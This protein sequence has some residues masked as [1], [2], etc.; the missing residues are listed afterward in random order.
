MDATLSH[1]NLMSG[2][3]EGDDYGPCRNR[4]ASDSNPALLTPK[5]AAKALPIAPRQGRRMLLCSEQDRDARRETWQSASAGGS[6][7]KGVLRAR[8]CT[9]AYVKTIFLLGSRSRVAGRRTRQSWAA[10]PPWT[11]RICSP[12]RARLRRARRGPK[13]E[14]KRRAN[15][16]QARSR[17][18]KAVR[19]KMW[20]GEQGGGEGAKRGE[21]S[22]AEA[23]AEARGG[24]LSEAAADL[25]DAVDKVLGV[26]HL[27]ASAED[28]YELA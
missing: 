9:R 7:S 19:A 13:K 6:L 27:V 15:A 14:G 20:R 12:P 18:G 11:S 3:R 23:R 22:R 5:G 26:G 10:R 17:G 4:A 25:I 24:H 28:R 16:W 8:M 1:R 2:W 21:G